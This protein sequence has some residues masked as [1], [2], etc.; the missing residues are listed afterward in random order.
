[1]YEI[2]KALE[3]ISYLDKA[4]SVDQLKDVNFRTKNFLKVRI[5]EE[6]FNEWEYRMRNPDAPIGRY[7]RTQDKVEW[8][9]TEE[10]RSKRRG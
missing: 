7:N 6:S 4:A 1:M 3:S 10:I 9:L 5:G 2:K 8:I